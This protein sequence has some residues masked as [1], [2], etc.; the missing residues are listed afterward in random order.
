MLMRMMAWMMGKRYHFAAFRFKSREDED[1]LCLLDGT[2]VVQLRGTERVEKDFGAEVKA[3][4]Y[5]IY[6]RV[7]KEKR[8]LPGSETSDTTQALSDWRDANFGHDSR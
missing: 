2:K 8:L 1:V 5:G 4:F 7:R 3:Y 6:E